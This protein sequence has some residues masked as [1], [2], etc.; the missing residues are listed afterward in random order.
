MTTATENGSSL[1]LTPVK[2]SRRQRQVLGSN[3]ILTPVRRSLRLSARHVGG[4]GEGEIKSDG[5]N[6]RTMTS[7]DENI[8]PSSKATGNSK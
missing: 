4:G 1:V 7:E 2:A 8:V 5:V 3:T 6:Q